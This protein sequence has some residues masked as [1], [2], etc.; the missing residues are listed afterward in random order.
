M[1]TS[2][3]KKNFRF[4]VRT[5]LAGFFIVACCAA[6]LGA[7]YRQSQVE[8]QL[9]KKFAATDITYG[10]QGE[11]SSFTNLFSGPVQED[12]DN[13]GRPIKRSLPI[14]P[15]PKW[16][17][18]LLGEHCFARVQSFKVNGEQMNQEDFNPHEL[19]RF[20]ELKG[21]QFSHCNFSSEA[22][23]KLDNLPSIE[24]L[25]FRN[26]NFN[27]VRNPPLVKNLK[28]IGFTFCKGITRFDTTKEFENITSFYLYQTDVQFVQ[29]GDALSRF[30]AHYCDRLEVIKFPDTMP[31]ITRLGLGNCDRLEEI[32]FPD[33]M[34]RITN[35]GLDNCKRLSHLELPQ[36]TPKLERFILG[37]N[38][39]LKTLNLEYEL[40]G[41]Q[42]VFIE[43]CDALSSVT[44]P[45]AKY[46]GLHNLNSLVELKLL[47]DM[48]NLETLEVT[49]CPQLA[50]LDSCGQF[51]KLDRFT[52]SAPLLTVDSSCFS[53]SCRPRIDLAGCKA[54]TNLDTLVQLKC[55]WMFR[56]P[57]HQKVPSELEQCIQP[58][59]AMQSVRGSE[60]G[61]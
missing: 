9:L 16:L 28:T 43:K 38:H 44:V 49:G 31:R 8:Q 25:G 37:G 29:V 2:P 45:R 21:I 22:Y 7:Y 19:S 61:E 26:C 46:L 55:P 47:V 32:K 1:Q 59:A 13:F 27:N 10:Y 54:V 35:L 52:I 48:S 30:N 3:K 39:S 14:P 58:R 36:F 33:T 20:T 56:L 24:L 15:G 57:P 51:P 60:N 12:Y 5:L 34:P 4:R 42:G 17:R 41:C 23:L 53:Q 6:W 18:R 40:V 11:M 50:R